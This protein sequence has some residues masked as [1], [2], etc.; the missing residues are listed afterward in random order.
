MGNQPGK[1]GKQSNGEDQSQDDSRFELHKAAYLG[2]ADTVLKLLQKGA[3]VN[4]RDDDGRTP[5]YWAICYGKYKAAAALLEYRADT[6]QKDDEGM[7]V[8]HKAVVNS[9]LDCVKLLLTK[10]ADLEARDAE[11]RSPLHLAAYNGDVQIAKILIEAGAK[12]TCRDQEGRT[13]LHY[14]GYNGHKEFAALLID[15]GADVN[16]KDKGSRTAV[17]YAANNGH[18]EVLKTLLEGKADL[19][20]KDGEGKTALDYA[21]HM[22]QSQC[23]KVIT[24]YKEKTGE[25]KTKDQSTRDNS[26][27]KTQNTQPKPEVHE[28]NPQTKKP[29]VVEDEVMEF[30]NGDMNQSGVTNTSAISASP[31]KPGHLVRQQHGMLQID[32]EALDN[33]I[34]QSETRDQKPPL[35]SSSVKQPVTIM[36]GAVP[37]HQKTTTRIREDSDDESS[38]SSPSPSLSASTNPPLHED[39]L[40]TSKSPTGEDV[41]RPRFQGNASMS[42]T[43]TAPVESQSIMDLQKRLAESQARRDEEQRAFEKEKA[44]LESELSS[45]RMTYNLSKKQLETMHTKIKELEANDGPDSASSMLNSQI[46]QLQVEKDQLHQSFNNSQSELSRLRKQELQLREE[47]EAEKSLRKSQATKQDTTENE[48]SRYKTKVD[49]L[50]SRLVS[51]QS[52]LQ[53]A[54]ESGN[55][56]SAAITQVSALQQ[57]IQRLESVKMANEKKIKE[58][59]EKCNNRVEKCQQLEDEVEKLNQKVWELESQKRS[60]Q[61][62]IDDLQAEIHSKT[63]PE[64]EVQPVSSQQALADQVLGLK[65]DL[66]KLK[67]EKNEVHRNLESAEFQIRTLKQNLAS[68]ESQSQSVKQFVETLQSDVEIRSRERD[69]AKRKS[70]ELETKIGRLQVSIH[71]QDVLHYENNQRHMRTDKAIIGG[72]R[73]T[74]I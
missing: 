69:E 61:S 38:D 36:S 43:T 39:E 49:D 11:M 57:D 52:K 54:L 32:K 62:Q 19:D 44:E 15:K 20:I 18:T 41:R 48:L 22:G 64:R 14:A 37:S 12:M 35:S 60:L 7:T 46:K 71:L 40:K 51:T 59:Q 72:P 33:V 74:F 5:L 42:S 53:N 26:N 1:G 6:D 2:N 3:P 56:S 68:Q 63:S 65:A 9:H 23:I 17:A 70:I 16:C 25:G 67:Q 24:E 10:N 30:T 66:Q 50:E 27:E 13:P 29:A 21:N 73:K 55:S 45:I 58:L 31:S 4:A 47:L 28:P 8:L 34:K